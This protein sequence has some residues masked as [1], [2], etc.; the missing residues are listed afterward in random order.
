MKDFHKVGLG[1]GVGGLVRFWDSPSQTM[2]GTQKTILRVT[3]LLFVVAIQIPQES[4]DR[5][6][7]KRIASYIGCLPDREGTG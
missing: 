3:R 5:V 6:R 4:L 2:C 7:S 1:G